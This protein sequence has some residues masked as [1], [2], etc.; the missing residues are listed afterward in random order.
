MASKDGLLE[1]IEW[2]PLRSSR[3]WI[4]TESCADL[5]DGTKSVV[6]ERD[7]AYH[8]SASIQ[9]SCPSDHV[10][11]AMA[12]LEGSRTPGELVRGPDLALHTRDGTLAVS[13]YVPKTW[14]FNQAEPWDR[15]Q[16]RVAFFTNRI[17]EIAPHDA[18]IAWLTDWNLNGPRDTPWMR[19]SKRS[20]QSTF[21]RSWGTSASHPA[22]FR[23]AQ[24]SGGGIDHF[25]V[26]GD[27][28]EC[29]VHTVPKGIGPEWSS[30][31]GFTYLPSPGPLPSEDV[32]LALEEL[33]GFVFGRR[34]MRIASVAFDA[35]G[36]PK[37]SS[38]VSPWG[39]NVRGVC[40]KPDLA[41]LPFSFVREHSSSVEHAL[42][43]LLPTYLQL[44]EPLRLDDVL[45]RLWLGNEAP[46]TM[47]VPIF[48][49]GLEILA[50][51]WFRDTKSKSK[52]TYMPKDDFDTLLEDEL[53]AISSKLE[54]VPFGDRMLRKIKRAYETSGNERLRWFFDDVGLPIGPAEEDALRARNQ[55]VHPTRAHTAEESV[56][57][58]RT[59]HVYRT[60]MVRAIL[61]ILSWNGGYLDY[62]TLGHPVRGLD[63][64][65]GG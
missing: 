11:P 13:G 64:P 9:G 50:S 44:R 19:A 57:F 22:E 25:V 41:F 12:R 40:A 55:A 4:L 24:T 46:S 59:A 14:T 18:D 47:D 56:G 15:A 10:A 53:T 28:W 23:G 38:M 60:L 62:G 35:A 21:A 45:W 58:I 31:V 3:E 16:L 8:L 5:P 1:R 36:F 43:S 52:G 2:E 42:T 32:R 51:A 6:V 29:V 34:L 65:S 61:K 48:A 39:T 33:V 20:F 17:T 37:L 63:E 49:A 30:N 7:A 27:G 26:A 54:G